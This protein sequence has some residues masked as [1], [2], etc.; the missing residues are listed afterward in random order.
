MFH[1][2]ILFLIKVDTELSVKM[3]NTPDWWHLTKA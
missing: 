2:K 1:P 3:K